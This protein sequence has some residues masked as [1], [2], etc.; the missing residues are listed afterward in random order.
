MQKSSILYICILFFS[1]SLLA[2][3]VKFSVDMT[4]REIDFWGVHVAGDFQV[5]AGVSKD[6]WNPEASKMIKQGNSNIYSIIINIPAHRKYEYRYFNGIEGYQQEFVPYPCRTLF[7][8]GD[9]RW[10]YLDSLRNDTT[11]LPL[12]TFEGLAPVGKKLLRFN[13]AL[14]QGIKENV[15]K[16]HVA[17]SWQNWKPEELTMYSFDGKIYEYIAYVDSLKPDV[18]YKFLNGNSATAYEQITGKCTQG[19]NRYVKVTTDTILPPVCLAS[20][21][22]CPTVAT[23]DNALLEKIDVFPNPFEAVLNIRFHDESP[24]HDIEI[25]SILGELVYQNKQYT[26]NQLHIEKANVSRGIY[27]IKIINNKQ[28]FATFKINAI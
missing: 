8:F 10:F 11:F 9:N 27:F 28:Q 14:P 22:A 13:V 12:V 2:K 16:M 17:G 5:A 18:A 6:N 7:E 1:T 25:Y 4:G 15:A 21:E 26:G 23:L 19:G 3:Q 20:C 24:T